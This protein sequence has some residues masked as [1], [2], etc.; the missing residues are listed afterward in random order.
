M[1]CREDLGMKIDQCGVCDGDGRCP[2]KAEFTVEPLVNQGT[3]R[4]DT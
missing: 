4:R 3:E 1:C 2:L